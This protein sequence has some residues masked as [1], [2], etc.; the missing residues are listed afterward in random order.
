MSNTTSIIDGTTNEV[1]K[2]IPVGIN[3]QGVAINPDTNRIYVANFGSNT[4]SV[5][6]GTTNEV[7]KEIPVG[8]NP[9]AVAVNPDTNLLYV[10]NWGTDFISVVN[11]DTFAVLQNIS[12]P[13]SI[14]NG[15][16][17]SPAT[18]SIYLA[19]CGNPAG[20]A[21]INS[22][23]NE[24]VNNIYDMGPC[25][26]TFAVDRLNKQVYVGDQY[27]NDLFVIDEESGVQTD[28]QIDYAG[29]PIRGLAVNPKEGILY[30][31]EQ[32]TNTLLAHNISQAAN[33]ILRVNE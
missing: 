21:V 2:E 18:N 28:T 3:P 9:T 22:T 10:A 6:D 4:T 20:I 19:N 32:G 12:I 5:I 30:I 33:N 7:I 11:G 24:V 8:I 23:T 25:P 16:T 29:K 26:L 27:T 13:D 15:I 17:F 14:P 31:S 1:I